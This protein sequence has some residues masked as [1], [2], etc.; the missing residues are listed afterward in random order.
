MADLRPGDMVNVTIKGVRAVGHPSGRLA[1]I[2]DEHG[3]VYDL[4]PQAALTRFFPPD[5]PPRPGDVWANDVGMSFFALQ[6][7]SDSD[8]DGLWLVDVAGDHTRARGLLAGE[9]ARLSLA[10]REQLEPAAIPGRTPAEQRRYGLVFNAVSRAL[11]EV[12]R[13][14]LLSDRQRIT[15]LVLQDL[16]EDGGDGP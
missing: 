14:A 15:E 4:P 3:D 11:S 8:A 1:R 2:A 12:G 7:D 10:H 6:A 5:W 16:D 9:A 13:F